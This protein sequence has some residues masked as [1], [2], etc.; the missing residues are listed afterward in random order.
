MKSNIAR[1]DW[2]IAVGSMGAALSA[3]ALAQSSNGNTTKPNTARAGVASFVS[4][5]ASVADGT[6][7]A[8]PLT[9]GTVVKQGQAIETGAN[10]EVQIVFDDGGL[11]ALRPS[12][13]IQ[14]DHAQISGAFNDSLT[15]TLLRGAMRSITGWIGKFDR[16]SYQ[17]RTATA[18]VGIRGTDHELAII[19]DGEEKKGEVAGV[20]NWV[21]EGGTTLTNANGHTD[22]E[23]GHAAW[24]PHN[25]Q[26]PRLHQGIP[27]FLQR[28]KSAHEGRINAHAQRI[29]Q[30]IEQRMRSRGM[31]KPG[32][33][34]HEAVQRHRALR[35]Q[36][37]ADQ[38]TPAATTAPRER[39]HRFRK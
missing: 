37:E 27:A 34:L 39:R 6:A 3:P 32:E 19:A 33:T 9:S 35:A 29:A 12:S 8:Q 14:I 38:A 17:L 30:H 20:H 15:M 36:P 16:N 24:A 28:R 7:L 10:G 13:R 11:L 4:G 18:T 21:H 2:V 22:V 26:A 1:R 25:G 31:I 23:P 5:D